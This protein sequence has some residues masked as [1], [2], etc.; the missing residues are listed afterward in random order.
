MVRPRPIVHAAVLLSLDKGPS[1]LQNIYSLCREYLGVS[2]QEME[3]TRPDSTDPVFNHEVRCS[4]WTLSN[5][6]QVQ[7][8]MFETW[9]L[10]P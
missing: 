9:G 2:D 6:G 8:F 10:T 3:I 1:P 7:N 5:Q 4:L